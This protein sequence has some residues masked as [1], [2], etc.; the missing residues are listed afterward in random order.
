MIIEDVIISKLQAVGA[1]YP[2][3]MPT[4]ATLPGMAYQFISEVNFPN[5]SGAGTVR[6]R[7]Q[8][9]CWGRTYAAAVTLADSVKSALSFNKTNIELI[10]PLDGAN[11]FKDPEAKLYR[12][13][14]EFYVWN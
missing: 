2:L 12:R 9:A 14:A 4:G 1:A 10:A 3:T 7:L 6:R 5:H 11:D 8:V 13:I